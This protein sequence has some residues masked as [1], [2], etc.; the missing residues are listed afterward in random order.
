MQNVSRTFTFGTLNALG[1]FISKVQEEHACLQAS[2][3]NTYSLFCAFC[4]TFFLLSQF[5]MS[6]LTHHLCVLQRCLFL[7]KSICYSL[8]CKAKQRL[9]LD[10]DASVFVLLSSFCSDAELSRTAG[11]Q[12]LSASITLP[13]PLARSLFCSIMEAQL[14]QRS[15][16]EL[17]FILRFAFA[18]R[19]SSRRVQ[20]W[21]F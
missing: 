21:M 6:G 11:I 2:T 7:F 15:K 12:T 10:I 3:V 5:C 9:I 1:S 8:F 14:F 16:G 13:L 4:S 17:L 20:A 18:R 19:V